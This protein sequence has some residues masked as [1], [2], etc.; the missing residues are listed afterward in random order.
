MTTDSQLYY[1][2]SD[3]PRTAY[4]NKERKRNIHFVHLILRSTSRAA[5]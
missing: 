2:E 4:I 3:R 5:A 1:A